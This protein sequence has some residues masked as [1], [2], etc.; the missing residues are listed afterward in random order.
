MKKPKDRYITVSYFEERESKNMAL[1]VK[2]FKEFEKRMDEKFEILR[3]EMRS[4]FESV[5]RRMDNETLWTVKQEQHMLL[6]KRVGVLEKKVG[7]I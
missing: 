5:H 1:I 3:D 6:E 2:W 4:G 7:S